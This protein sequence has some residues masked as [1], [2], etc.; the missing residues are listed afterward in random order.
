LKR[1]KSIG[2]VDRIDTYYDNITSTT[3]IH[4]MNRMT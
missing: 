4:F 3:S 2:S 1:I